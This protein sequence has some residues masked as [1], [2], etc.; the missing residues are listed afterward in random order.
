MPVRF[1]IAL[2]L[3]NMTSVRAKRVLLT[4]Y[5]IKLGA[6]PVAIGMLAASFILVTSSPRHR[7]SSTGFPCGVARAAAS[8]SSMRRA[9]SASGTSC[10][11]ATSFSS[12]A[13]Q[14]W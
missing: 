3:F 10:F 4:L 7:F 12:A 9:S 1:V 14:C 13:S 11:L 5:A 2:A 6:Q 8:H